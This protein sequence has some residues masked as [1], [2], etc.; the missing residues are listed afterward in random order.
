MTPQL[1]NQPEEQLVASLSSVY[2]RAQCIYSRNLTLKPQASKNVN[3]SQAN[4][5][6]MEYKG[7]GAVGGRERP[8]CIPGARS[9]SLKPYFF[10]W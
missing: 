7:K 3:R 4:K 5:Q 10:G 9:R 6:D 2:F 1:E 8:A